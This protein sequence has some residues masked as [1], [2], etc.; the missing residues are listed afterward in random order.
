MFGWHASFPVSC[1]LLHHLTSIIDLG[2]GDVEWVDAAKTYPHLLCYYGLEDLGQNFT[3]TTDM[4]VADRSAVRAHAPPLGMRVLFHV[5]KE[6]ADSDHIQAEAKLLISNLLS[7]E[8][9]P[10]MVSCL[11]YLWHLAKLVLICDD[12]PWL[13]NNEV[14]LIPCLLSPG[15]AYGRPKGK[16]TAFQPAAGLCAL[17]VEHAG[18]TVKRLV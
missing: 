12:M 11:H 17:I 6:V 18:K 10:V 8:E 14:I 13:F 7:P 9:R 2:Q 1:R 5:T 4:L 15:L 3:G 16:P